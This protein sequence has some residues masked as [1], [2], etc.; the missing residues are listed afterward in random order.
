MQQPRVCRHHHSKRQLGCTCPVCLSVRS[1]ACLPARFTHCLPLLCGGATDPERRGASLATINN[2]NLT[3]QGPM[4]L[5][6]GFRGAVA[7][8]AVF[9]HNVSEDEWFG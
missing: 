2:G 4:M 8:T 9:I 7:R 3:M 1:P 5:R 6:Q